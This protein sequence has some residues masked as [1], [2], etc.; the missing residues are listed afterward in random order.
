MNKGVPQRHHPFTTTN[1]MRYFL[2]AG[3]ASGDLHASELM[4][5]LK[6]ADPEAEFAFY[7]GDCMAAVGGTLLRHYKD[8]AYMGFIPVLLHLRTILQGMADCKRQI[9]EWQRDALILVDYPGL[10]LKMARFVHDRA[11][12]PVF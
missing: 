7:G 5:A 1:K 2:I 11:I 12:C 10:N 3:E 9:A 6:A 4:K 8:L